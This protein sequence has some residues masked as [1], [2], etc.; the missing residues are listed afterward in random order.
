[1][2]LREQLEQFWF[3]PASA[4]RLA[5][6]RVLIV[7]YGLAWLLG[8]GPMLV[9]VYAYPA[10]QFAPVGLVSAL[11]GPLPTSGM[12]VIHAITLLVGVAALLGWR[13]RVSGP[14]Y[15]LGLTWVATYRN[16][17]GMVFHTEN[18][19]VMHTLILAV[20]PAAD[21]WSIDAK[22]A[23][24][25]IGADE[26]DARY[27]WG[28]KLMAAVTVIAYL[29]AGIAKLRNAGTAWLG[30]DVL[31]AH[32]AWDN[33]RKLE[34]GSFHSPLG[35]WL[36]AHPTAFIP[37][38]WMSV[39]LE[40]GAPLALLGGW[41]ARIWALAMWGFHLGVALIMAIVFAYPLSGIAFAPLFA[42]D[43]PLLAWA[44][45]VRA[46]RPASILARVL[47]E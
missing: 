16:S 37:L 35:A 41:V 7:G 2:N 38:A 9:G 33:L 30:G 18:L 15:A 10:E 14:I 5:S 43:E 45:R 8:L 17:W 21:R 12:V 42:I 27:G 1:M 22:R 29:L 46:R 6:L 47:P 13:F 39:A 36:S 40:L 24:G 32:V 34:L 4:L 11:D 20:L 25:Q 44:R 28:P 23:V 26:L 31:L 19:L 3:A